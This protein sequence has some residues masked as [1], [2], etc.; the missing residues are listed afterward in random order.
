MI[1]VNMT[2]HRGAHGAVYTE[3]A[4]A[5]VI[6]RD[7]Q[8]TKVDV[9]TKAPQGRLAFTNLKPGTYFVEPALRPC[10]ANCG[11]L[12]ARVDS[13]SH[14]L[15]VDGRVDVKVDFIV[16]SRCRIHTY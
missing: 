11:Y 1:A 14:K 9:Q 2:Q 8:G 5:E 15:E 12:D 16:G 4:M 3:G 6:L 10:D 13:C 7:A